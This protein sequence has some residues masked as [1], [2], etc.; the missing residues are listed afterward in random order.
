MQS[1]ARD[2]PIAAFGQ[3]FLVLPANQA[4]NEN[5]YA[6]FMGLIKRSNPQSS[7]IVQLYR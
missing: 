1:E 3:F 5:A 4:T 2:V 6:E 7:D